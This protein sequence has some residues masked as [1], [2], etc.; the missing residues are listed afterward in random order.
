MRMFKQLLAS[1]LIVSCTSSSV[2][3]M[4]RKASDGPIKDDSEVPSAN[5][6]KGDTQVDTSVFDWAKEMLD[7]AEA[8]RRK[9]QKEVNMFVD[10]VRYS[11][12]GI[13]RALLESI[14]AEQRVEFIMS[15][16]SCYGNTALHTVVLKNRSIA[17]ARMLLDVVPVERRV[18][19]ITNSNLQ[20]CGSIHLAA[21]FD[22][23]E[24][25]REMLMSIPIEQR[26]ACIMTKN[27]HGHTAF[28][29]AKSHSERVLKIFEEV[30][31]KSGWGCS[32]Q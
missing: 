15:G 27:E 7:K 24:L 17:I 19:F 9:R 6:K 22:R 25:A 32:I 18:E 4:K 26:A 28:L 23:P 2:F 30:L 14:P 11:E 13:I 21:M 5:R 12:E 10:A 31:P 16:E 20:L 8:I 1:M 29:Y 3:G